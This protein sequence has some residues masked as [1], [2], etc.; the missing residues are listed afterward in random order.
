[1]SDEQRGLLPTL[2]ICGGLNH[3]STRATSLAE[4]VNV[5]KFAVYCGSPAGSLILE[6][7]SA[8]ITIN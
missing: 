7:D 2:L 1:M 3:Q 8:R 4:I 5:L 6:W